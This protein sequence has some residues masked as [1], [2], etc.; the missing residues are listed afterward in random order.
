MITD[1][2][3][4]ASN[5]ITVDGITFKTSGNIVFSDPEEN[6]YFLA[7]SSLLEKI[8]G[9]LENGMQQFLKKLKT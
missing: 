6:P 1:K 4:N 3:E 9:L 8:D 7:Q 5:T 2:H